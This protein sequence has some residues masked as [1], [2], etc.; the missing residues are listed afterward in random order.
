MRSRGFSHC[1]LGMGSNYGDYLALVLGAPLAVVAAAHQNVFAILAAIRRARDLL[2]HAAVT[3]IIAAIIAVIV[4]AAVKVVV[5]VA[6]FVA[7][8][9]LLAVSDRAAEFVVLALNLI[10]ARG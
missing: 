6:A 9:R 5:L 10:A 2:A 3:A 7:V 4:R 8:I 1:V